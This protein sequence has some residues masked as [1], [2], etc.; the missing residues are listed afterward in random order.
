MSRIVFIGGGNMGRALIGG[1]IAQGRDPST[2][3]VVEIDAGA[4]ERLARE[5]AVRAVASPSDA[6]VRGAEAIVVAVK[7]QGMR[8]TA[9]SIAPHLTNAL[10]ISIAAGIRLRDLSRWLGDYRKLVR[11]MPN[12]PALIRRGIT[13]LFAEDDV[14]AGDRALAGTILGAVGET[15]WCDR[16]TQIDAITAV[17]GSGPAYLFYF[18]ESMIAS[19]EALGF[20]ADEARRLAYATAS[21]AMALA[22]S[23]S[24][25]ASTLRAQVTSKKGTTQAALESLDE[26][27]VKAAFIEAVKRADARARELG[28][29]LGRD[30]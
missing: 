25:T 13:G 6:D 8:D 3:D 19:A 14:T 11:A 27:G 29:E 18:L 21:G 4:R 20:T 1:L 9:K 23:S 15:I 5:S 26:S 10:V 22:E 24:E 2:I 28:D 12:T 16:E 7:P 17:S 30:G